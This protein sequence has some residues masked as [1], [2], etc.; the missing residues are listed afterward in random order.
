[1][2]SNKRIVVMAMAYLGIVCDT[3]GVPNG[4]IYA[5]MMNRTN[6]DDHAAAVALL[7]KKGW[8]SE[9]NYYLTP[10]ESGKTFNEELNKALGLAAL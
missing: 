1:M 2:D 6:I 3:G 4:H 8:V 9:E 7:C 10:T 5:M